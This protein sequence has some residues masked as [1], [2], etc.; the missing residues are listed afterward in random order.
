MGAPTVSAVVTAHDRRT[1]LP[2][3]VG[4]ALASGADEVIVV[5]NFSGPIEGCEGRYRDVPC[6]VPDTGEK[7]A[8]G[9]AAAEGDVVAFLD[10]DDLW[11]TAKVAAVRER[12]ASRPDLIYFC[13]RQR[14]IDVEGRWVDASHPELTG[15]DP[16]RFARTDRADLRTLVEE[17]WPGNNSS[18]VVSRRWAMGWLPTL[19]AAGWSC[20]LFWFV[21]ALLS[22]GEMELSPT[23]L[24]RLRLHDRNMSSTR[25]ASPEE[26]RR[27]HAEASARFARAYDVLARATGDRRGAG[28][29]MG[30]YLSESAV[31]FHFFSDLESGLRP[32]SA[33]ARALRRGPGLHRSGVV[34]SALVTLISPAVARRLVY[35]SSV[36]R[37]R[38]G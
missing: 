28:S 18:T 30:R 35:R 29:A 4:S 9:V 8:R 22:D 10:D 11:E 33:A 6:D 15:K 34:G 24:V 36:R 21:A 26:F 38:L 7:E 17:V 16:T 31:A 37:W 27:R 25:G 3:A 13:H 23:P 19:R 32:R 5:R 2:D 1:F 12:F 20:D 14:P